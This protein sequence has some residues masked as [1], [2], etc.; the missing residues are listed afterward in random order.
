MEEGYAYV[1]NMGAG[2][3]ILDVSDPANPGLAGAYSSG[4]QPERCCGRRGLLLRRG[5]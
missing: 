2:V 1:A 4:G 3:T 5:L